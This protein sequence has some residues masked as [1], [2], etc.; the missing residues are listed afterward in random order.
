M[1]LQALTSVAER[2]RGEFLWRRQQNDIAATALCPGR[3]SHVGGTIS[4]GHRR[5]ETAVP[6]SDTEGNELRNGESIRA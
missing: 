2:E 6:E 1:A 3:S 4:P 5:S